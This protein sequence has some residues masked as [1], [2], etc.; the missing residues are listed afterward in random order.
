MSG[1][2]IDETTKRTM[3]FEDS[4]KAGALY[5]K[6]VELFGSDESVRELFVNIVLK[7]RE[8]GLIKD[9]DDSS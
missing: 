3:S 7:A 8:K 2:N 4:V 1:S 6:F 5:A 9:E